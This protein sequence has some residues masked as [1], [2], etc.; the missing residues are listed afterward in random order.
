[1]RI[2]VQADDGDQIS[3]CADYV[4]AEQAVVTLEIENELYPA[5][6]EFDLLTLTV[7]KARE[8]AMALLSV[9]DA[10]EFVGTPANQLDWTTELSCSGWPQSRQFS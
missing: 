1:M 2:A 6:S 8:L 4:S 10:V 7:A 9:A 3:I 5:D